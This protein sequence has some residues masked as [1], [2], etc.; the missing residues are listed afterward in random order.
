MP[1]AD[2]EVVIRTVNDAD[3]TAIAEIYMHYVTN[4]V[5][6][7][8]EETVTADELTHK[9]HDCQKLNLPWLVAVTRATAASGGASAAA[10]TIVGYAYAGLFRPRTGWRFTIEDSIY[11][12]PGFAGRGIG[13]RLLSDLLKRCAAAGYKQMIAAISIDDSTGDGAS[14]VGLHK[15]LGFVDAGRLKNVGFK[16]NRWI[17]CGFLQL[18]LAAEQSSAT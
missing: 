11:L 9:F 8:G 3:I 15:S 7:F 4:T 6:T 10:E 1:D 17:D 2:T 18:D 12:R 14:S 13:R 5:A 16:F